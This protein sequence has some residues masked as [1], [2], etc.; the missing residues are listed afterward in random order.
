MH[1]LQ[2]PRGFDATLRVLGHGSERYMYYTSG[3]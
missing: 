1:G 2:I 3:S